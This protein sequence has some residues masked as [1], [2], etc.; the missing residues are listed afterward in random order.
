MRLARAERVGIERGEALERRGRSGARDR[1]RIAAEKIAVGIAAGRTASVLVRLLAHWPT[2]P[3]ITAV[4]ASVS[5][6][7]TVV[8]VG[9]ESSA[10]SSSASGSVATGTVFSTSIRIGHE[11]KSEYF[12][13]RLLILNSAV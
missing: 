12:L 2:A 8:V 13:T 3:S 4:V 1:R 5:V 10:S 11:M 6:S 7:V 9:S